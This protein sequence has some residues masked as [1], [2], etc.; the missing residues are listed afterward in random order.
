MIW[1]KT[2]EGY[3]GLRMPHTHSSSG[4]IITFNFSSEKF[5]K[6]HTILAP[7]PVCQNFLGVLM[8]FRPF[9]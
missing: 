2:E 5:L 3:F 6:E 8:Y 4:G 9:L 1:F 7:P